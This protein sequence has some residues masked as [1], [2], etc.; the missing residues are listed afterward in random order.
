MTN[1]VKQHVQMAKQF[2]QSDLEALQ[3]EARNTVME[4]H[5]QSSDY[6]AGRWIYPA[7]AE[8]QFFNNF[9]QFLAY[10]GEMA[11][12]GIPIFPFDSPSHSPAHW[13]ITFYRPQE[14]ID[15]LL[16]QSDLDVEQQYKADIEAFN[17]QQIELLTTQLF[18]Q[19]K[20]KERKIQEDKDSKTLAAAHA[21]A[22][23]FIQ[24]Q[25]GAK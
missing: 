3:A 23:K 16:T 24:S 10:V 7:A 22:E 9:E 2:N 6:G 18:E 25:L 11:V 15:V 17:Q 19:K 1:Q 4:G 21:Q 5:Y 8:R 14:E 12:A 20:A 13:S